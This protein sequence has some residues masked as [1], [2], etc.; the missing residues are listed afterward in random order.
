MS[1]VR[2]WHKTDVQALVDLLYGLIQSF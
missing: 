1:S 2:F